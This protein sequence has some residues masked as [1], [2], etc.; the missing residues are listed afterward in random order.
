MA[1]NPRNPRLYT[2]FFAL[3]LSTLN[4]ADS[5]KVGTVAARSGETEVMV[6]ITATH[7]A[8]GI[9]GFSFGIRYD[10]D[11]VALT[12]F[13][14]QG[15][16]TALFD[17]DVDLADIHNEADPAFA[18]YGVLLEMEPSLPGK[19]LPPG[20]NQHVVTA[21]FTVL[22]A[23]TEGDVPVELVDGL[24]DPPIP[25]EFV[26]EGIPP[27]RAVPDLESG[28]I[29]VV[30]FKAPSDIQCDLLCG[31]ASVLVSW[32]NNDAY[33]TVRVERDNIEIAQEPAGATSFLDADV[34]LGEHSYRIVGEGATGTTAASPA[35]R[36][37]VGRPT[38]IL[39][40]PSSGSGDVLLVAS[41]GTVAA[42]RPIGQETTP[43]GVAV[44]VDGLIWITSPATDEVYRLNQAG[45]VI[46]DPL[47]TG[48][49]PRGIAAA[50]NGDMLLVNAGESSLMRLA[51]DGTAILGGGGPGIALPAGAHAVAVGPRGNG[52]VAAQSA[53][54][55]VAPS[56]AV[57]VIRIDDLGSDVRGIG[58]DRRG[59]AWATVRQPPLLLRL[60]FDGRTVTTFSTD[61][62]PKHVAVDAQG[63]IWITSPERD[64]VTVHAGDGSTLQRVP[65]PAGTAPNGLAVAGDGSV[66]VTSHPMGTR[67]GE[68][69]KISGVNFTIETFPLAV[70][71]EAFGDMVGFTLAELSHPECDLD[72]DGFSS[73]EELNSRADPFSTDVTPATVIEG[74]V[75]PVGGLTCSVDE[76]DVTLS[77]ELRGTYESISIARDGTAIATLGGGETHFFDSDLRDGG[78][79]YAVVAR[80]ATNESE[81]VTCLAS[82]GNLSSA[83]LPVTGANVMDLA[84]GAAPPTKDGLLQSTR[85]YVLDTYSGTVEVIDAEGASVAEIPSPFGELVATTGVALGTQERWKD[86]SQPV[87]FLGTHLESGE[88]RLAIVNAEGTVL[89]T[90]VPLEGLDSE[91]S[92]FAADYCGGVDPEDPDIF[93]AAVDPEDPDIF[94]YHLDEE[95]IPQLDTTLSVENLND[96]TALV[97]TVGACFNPTFG[98][99]ATT[100]P[101]A[102]E[103]FV[104]LV[105]LTEDGEWKFV[106]INISDG[107]AAYMN[108]IDIPVRGDAILGVDTNGTYIF[109]TE[110]L[111]GHVER[112]VFLGGSFRRG[113]ANVD[114]S[115]NIADA[116]YILQNLFANG[117]AIRCPNAA[118]SNDDE[119][120]NIADGIYILQNLFANGPAIPAP[121]PDCGKDTTPNLDPTKAD[122]RGCLYDQDLCQ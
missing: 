1:S 78:Y 7:D 25:V 118:D 101:G 83:D 49:Q 36:V 120:V 48:Q 31:T 70:P 91:M 67:G 119:S 113:D 17:P 20:R 97:K 61:E 99:V 80:G 105:G 68:V 100:G 92:V 75:P 51:A 46:G 23:I 4:A 34:P 9:T 52:W 45:E 106:E 6:P 44:N 122:L 121:H 84:V 19:A 71:T 2:V 47:P 5:L 37:F 110:A 57:T 95:R 87:Y 40:L 93:F 107:T 30:P 10:G 14:T 76:D 74:L 58:V 117:P 72:A 32:S 59:R 15:S 26:R 96:V 39:A 65:L 89:Q 85:I 79:L 35:C 88:N 11:R 27:R 112:I 73:R 104:I 109:L 28:A 12:E 21:V 66:W 24:G 41:D 77:W 102:Y 103:L 64:R 86:D 54:A 62:D 98:S 3:S 56:G 22:P 50:P 38:G 29:R 69:L 81:A 111:A 90:P 53:V 60:S 8:Y 16:T 18:V 33:A 43:T 108:D 115:V 55:R 82:V 94:V 13:T 114:G 63:R 116:I 42:Q